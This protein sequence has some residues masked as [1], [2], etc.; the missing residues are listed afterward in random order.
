MQRQP[1][2]AAKLGILQKLRD[3]LSA[4]QASLPHLEGSMPSSR[5]W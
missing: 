3:S 1:T 2:K 4:N 5:R